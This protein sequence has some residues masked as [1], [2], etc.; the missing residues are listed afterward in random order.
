M[1]LFKDQ[2]IA[3]DDKGALI[4]LAL[5]V[6]KC[7]AVDLKCDALVRLVDDVGAEMSDA[8][9]YNRLVLIRRTAGPA[10]RREVGSPAA[11]KIIE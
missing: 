5:P 6:W 2:L 8:S 1:L 4:V 9:Y 10:T 3:N 11:I 7:R